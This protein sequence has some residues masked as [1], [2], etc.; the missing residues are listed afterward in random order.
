MSHGC[1]RNG[2]FTRTIRISLE[3][4]PLVV[5]GV[6]F[7][8]AANNAFALDARTGRVIW[9]HARPISE[10][11]IDDASRPP[12]SA[13]WGFGAT[14]S[15]WKPTRSPVMSRC[16]VPATSCGM[17]LTRLEQDYGATSAPLVVKDKSDRGNVGRR[18]RRAR[19]IAA[20]DARRASSDGAFLSHSP[21]G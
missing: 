16:A 19:F 10:G 14:A 17:W 8:T 6:M 3:V 5:D 13:A 11:L 2:C 4:N 9:R 18:R 12:Q 21:P 20:Y 7:V 15:S 1:A